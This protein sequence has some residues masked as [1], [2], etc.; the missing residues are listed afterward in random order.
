MVSMIPTLTVKMSVC[1]NPILYIA[2]N[3]QVRK[4]VYF[5][6]IHDIRVLLLVVYKAVSCEK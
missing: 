3:R 1:I 2:L 4:I 5:F 6:I